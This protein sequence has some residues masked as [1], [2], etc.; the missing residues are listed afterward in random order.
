MSDN[1]QL[2]LGA[3]LGIALIL[4]QL[5]GNSGAFNSPAKANSFTV[6]VPVTE[7]ETVSTGGKKSKRN[8]HKIKSDK[9]ITKKS[10]K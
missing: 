4:F 9:K 1:S 6:P 10:R 5:L 2:I 3:V 7:T 8:S